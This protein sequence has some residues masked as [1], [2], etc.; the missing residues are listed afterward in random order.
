MS[1]GLGEMAFADADFADDEHGGV[2]GDVA[3]GCEVMHECAV[4]LRQPIEV[5]LVEGLV[6][7]KGGAAQSQG[8]LLVLAAGD[9]IV[10]EKAQELG[11]GEL[12]VDGLAVTGIKGVEDAGEAQLF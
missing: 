7:A 4:E 1:E 8:E 5:E 2:L 3:T 6:G 10:Y 12:G 11:V 9:F